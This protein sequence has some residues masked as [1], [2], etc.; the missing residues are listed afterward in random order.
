[1]I[2]FESHGD[3]IAKVMYSVKYLFVKRNFLLFELSSVFAPPPT[4]FPPKS[5]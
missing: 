2:S 4:F 5:L 1:M 3:R